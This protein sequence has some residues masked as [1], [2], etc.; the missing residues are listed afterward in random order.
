M[1]KRMTTGI[2][3][4]LLLVWC[5]SFTSPT[6]R[7]PVLGTKAPEI[8]LAGTD[9]KTVKLSSLKGKVV[10]IDFWASWCGPC[11]KENPNVVEVY[12]KYKKAKF[13]SAKGFE[14]F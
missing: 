3:T 5:A 6:K 7:G 8:E 13:K 11:R 14:V 10:L 2:V 12:N 4:G 1:F 9:G